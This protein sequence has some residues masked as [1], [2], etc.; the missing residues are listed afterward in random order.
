[1]RTVVITFLITTTH[2]YRYTVQ[3]IEEKHDTCLHKNKCSQINHL[4]CRGKKSTSL[5]RFF[6][7]KCNI[8]TMS[9]FSQS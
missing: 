9:P 1:M 3:E 4:H 8:T 5:D 7:G 6:L 2:A